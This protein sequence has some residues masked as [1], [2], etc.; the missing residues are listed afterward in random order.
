MPA[1]QIYL[2]WRLL[3][4]RH[5]TLVFICFRSLSVL[6]KVGACQFIQAQA[7]EVWGFLENTVATEEYLYIRKVFGPHTG[8]NNVKVF[9]FQF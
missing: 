5:Y 7:Y 4:L 6:S 8:I 9:N 3:Y 2:P 1:D